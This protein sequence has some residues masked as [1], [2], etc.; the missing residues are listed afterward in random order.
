MTRK[1]IALLGLFLIL[2]LS[3]QTQAQSVFSGDLEI[4][5]NFYYMDSLLLGNNPPPQ[6]E[7][8]LTSTEGWLN[9]NYSN[10]EKGLYGGVRFDLFNNSGLRNPAEA[11]TDQGVGYWF[12]RKNISDLE[13]TVGNFYEQFG[14]GITFRAYEARGQNLDYAIQGIH[15]KYYLGKNW[16][17]KAFTGRQKFRFDNYAPVIKGFSAE[18]LLP[19]KDDFSL[20]LGGSIV[21]RTLD[22]NTMDLIVANINSYKVESRFV[23]KYNVYTYSFYNTLNY[24][25]FSLYAE[26]AGKTKEAVSFGLGNAQDSLVNKPGSVIYGSLS[27][28][29]KGFGATVQYKRTER[30]ELRTSPLE[31][32]NNGLISFIPPMTRVN[33]YRLTSRYLAA[34][35][36]IGEQGLQFDFVASV[37]KKVKLLLNY[38][39]ITKLE[40]QFFASDQSEDRLFREIYFESK[41]KFNKKLKGVFG[42]QHVVYNQELYEQKPGKPLVQTWTPF[43]ELTYKFDRKKSL[44]V[45]LSNMF[46]DEEQDLGSW[47][48]ALAEFNLAPRYSIA[49]MDMYNYGNKIESQRIHYY[50]IFGVLNLG[51]NRFTL[52]YVKQVQ[53]VICTG[54]VCRIE[55]AFNGVRATLNAYF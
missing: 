3:F 15:A 53:G 32:I 25:N 46:I 37:G 2:F 22:D 55:P 52:G 13:I 54:G 44:R 29:K 12:I 8:Q 26:Y 34:T 17:L 39:D 50:T 36:L 38:S 11:Y 27:Y 19:I 18:G 45:E 24:K 1:K 42:L 41:I 49:V 33:T 14:S 6:Y 28:S 5:Q 43:T 10:N 9:L 35:Q 47:F 51:K 16:A 40:G 23:P 48:W 4:R 21:N 20:N 7:K 30:F 31:K